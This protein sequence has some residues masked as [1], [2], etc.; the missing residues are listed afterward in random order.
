MTCIED[1][2]SRIFNLKTGNVSVT[3]LNVRTDHSASTLLHSVMD[4]KIVGKYI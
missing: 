1:T 3:N 4:L 2:E